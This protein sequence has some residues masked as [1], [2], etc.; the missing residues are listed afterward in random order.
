[1]SFDLIKSALADKS[2]AHLGDLVFWA[3]SDARIDRSALESLWGGAQL[4]AALLPD[5]PSAE[6]ALKLAVREAQVGNGDRLI[7]LAKDDA[8]EIVYAV[9]REQ[10]PGDGSLDYSTEARITLD[11]QREVF[12]SDRPSNDLVET[13]RTRFETYRTTHHADDVRRTIVKTLHSF[14]AVTL[15]DG[16]G[17]Y[18]CPGPFAERLRRLQSAIERIGLSRVYLLPV[19]KSAEASQTLGE[20]ARSSIEAEL[21]ALKSE[22]QSFLAVPPD[23]ASTLM[24]R[25]DSFEA[26]R[27]RAKLYRDVLNVEVQDL[28]GQLKRMSAAIEELLNQKSAA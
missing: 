9:V 24:R 6:K 13:V 5:P 28:D 7:R 19:H 12:S 21:E 22:I 11:R 4:D 16:G 15:R 10:R 1:M 23:R 20:I 8:D 18:W 14:A 2:G 3:L 26:L 27:S 25:F 17:I